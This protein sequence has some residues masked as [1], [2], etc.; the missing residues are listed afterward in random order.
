MKRNELY[1]IRKNWLERHWSYQII[2]WDKFDYNI[3][4]N[5][6]YRKRSGRGSNAT[7]ND[8]I[9]MADTETSKKPTREIFDYDYLDIL[10][11]IKGKVFKYDKTFKEVGT[12][13][14]LRH[15]GI[16]M[17]SKGISK[18]DTFYEYLKDKYPYIFKEE[19]YSDIQSLEYI[20]EYL[21]N[22]EM[23]EER[24]DNHVVAFTISLR[25]FD[26]NLVTLWG[27]KP[28]D[29]VKCID[30][31]MQHMS[32]DDT[33]IY[34][35]NLAY[36]WVFLRKF[37][38]QKYGTP[39][40]Q[41]NTKSH[42]PIYIKWGNGL[43]LKDSL[44]LA[45]RSLDKWAKDM[46][47]EHKK[48]VGLWDYD[49]LRTQHEIYSKD[50]LTYIEHD[51]LA[52][53]EC[54]DKMMHTLNKYLFS[55]PY[56]A[57]GIPREQV[58][59]IGKAY[60]AKDL[61]NRL[62]LDYS[63]YIKAEKVYHGG[64]T[65]ANRHLVNQVITDGVQCYDFTSSYPYVLLSEKYPME[66]FTNCDDCSIESIINDNDNA[67][68]LKLILLNV[69]LKDDFIAMPAL[70]YSKCVKSINAVLDNGRVLCA[71]YLE[72]YL[73]ELDAKVIYSQ[74]VWDKH[75]CTNVEMAYKDYLPRWLTDY[76]YQLFVDKT[77]LKGGD[78]VAYALAKSKL[79]S[80]YGMMVQKCVKQEIVEDYSSGDYDIEEADPE[81]LYT[82]YLKNYN[83]ILPYQWGVWCTA[84][85]FYNLFNLGKCCDTWV[86][87]D[88]D[89]CYGIGWHD[90]LL[91]EYN[92]NCKRKLLANGYDKVV[93]NGKEYWLGIAV[94]EGDND[95]YSEYVVQGAKRYCGR[96]LADNELHITVAGVPKKGAA[97][98][99]D[100]INNFKPGLIFKGGVTGKKTHKYI[101]VDD[102]YID[103]YGNE[104][105][106][107]I[108]LSSCDYLL[109]SVEKVDW[110]SLISDEINIQIYEEI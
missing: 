87:S 33:I 72:I 60:N 8:I 63:Q 91:D 74:Y 66:K 58:R 23:P 84:Y 107:S 83:S 26:M 69:R 101:Y 43:I 77:K 2:Y 98:L 10:N 59:N 22:N 86:Y 81:E 55:M 90:D 36:D 85:A 4:S 88:T 71:D 109:D 3:L 62:C 25:A 20:Y 6:M 7:Y 47:V 49:K 54:I 15:V 102:I 12:I 44:I 80:I 53:V 31:L 27:H 51:T 48:A 110:M 73:T 82:K 41:L 1:N 65:H 70:Q 40:K 104:T 100:D 24:L 16:N 38:M 94:S 89:S 46:D 99:K 68:M 56:T 108:N 42:Y 45:Q 17:S 57:T 67:Y 106:D 28:S 5:I 39:D 9:I 18:I 103:E 78:A 19:A 105:G 50:E 35:H 95:T 61:F 97:C 34:F 75:I 93:F 76:I 29:M 64:Y 79:N 11:D 32:G 13:Q 52:G 30:S 92:N 21:S 14:E 96:C 37:I